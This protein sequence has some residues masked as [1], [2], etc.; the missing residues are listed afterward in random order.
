MLVLILGITACSGLQGS[1]EP[2]S[3]T[4]TPLPSDTFVPTSAT[5]TA[6]ATETTTPAPSATATNTLTPSAT[7]TETTTNTPAVIPTV[8]SLGAQVTAEL[9]S[10]RYGP[11]PEYLYLYALRKTA[12]IKL[13]GRTDVE[14]WRWVYVDGRN[15]CWVNAKFLDI[16]GD[17]LSLPE[18][19]PDIA[20]IPRSPYYA[21]TDFLGASRDG[22][23]VEV[24][25][26][27]IRLRAGDEEDESM[28]LYI[29]EVWRCEGGELLFEPLATND[30]SV[31]FV[32]EPGC[33]EPSHGRHYFQE[34]HGYA[35]PV[36]VQWPAYETVP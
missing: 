9:L 10:C 5:A 12:N 29:L 7:P 4:S 1:Q 25:W 2:P 3:R 6:T 21:P 17:W 14:N 23:I 19:Y 8:L 16:Q 26:N 36:E 27:P 28:L 30:T 13:I 31:I 24:S 34:K 20:R 18:V 35:G 33:S 11:G 15:K 22:T 32:D